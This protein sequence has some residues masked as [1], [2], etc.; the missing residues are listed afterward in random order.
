MLRTLLVLILPMILPLQSVLK[1]DVNL[2]NV[3]AT[4]QDEE[5]RYVGG[6]SREDFRLVED[7]EEVGV[8]IFETAAG[9]SSS[10]GILVDNSG[11]SAS[12]LG[13]IKSGVEGF[14]QRLAPEDEVFVMSFAI[15]AE[16]VHDLQ[17]DISR[18]PRAL[19]R[20]RSWG[21][22]V[23]YDALSLGIS[24]TVEVRRERKALIVLSDGND[25]QSQTSYLEVVQAAQSNIV[26]LYFVGIGPRM[27]LDTY[28]MDGLASMSGG[29][30]VLMGRDQSISA[31]LENIREELNHQYY[32]GYHASVESGFH[33][34]EVEVPGRNVTVRTRDGYLVQ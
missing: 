30:V 8:E 22:S 7:G 23:F 3:F 4:V 10:F 32:L 14:S 25:N 33:S 18:L 12:I 6:L 19:D 31:A 5:G 34:I 24:K 29:R 2:V 9:L 16:I 11:S 27:L 1:V 17:E 20:L 13:S 15:E 28:T 21:T 26:L